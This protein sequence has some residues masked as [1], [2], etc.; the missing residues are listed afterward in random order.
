MATDLLYLASLLIFSPAGTSGLR[1]TLLYLSPCFLLLD[2]NPHPILRH[3]FPVQHHAA[4]HTGGKC[5][6][7]A[8]EK[9]SVVGIGILHFA[10]FQAYLS[11]LC[12]CF[13][14]IPAS[15][16]CAVWGEVV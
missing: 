6:A 2:S 14:H 1:I 10:Q 9:V 8:A 5:G 3:T 16:I 11:V 15:L 13:L 4:G 7:H 12:A